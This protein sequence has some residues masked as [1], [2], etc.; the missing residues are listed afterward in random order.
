M[1]IREYKCRACGEEFEFFA[2]RSSEVASC[3]KCDGRELDLAFSVFSSRSGSGGARG[4][5]AQRS[6]PRTLGAAPT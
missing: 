5:E 3:P 2:A 1:P 4:G 6:P